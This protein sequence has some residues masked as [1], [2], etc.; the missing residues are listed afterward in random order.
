MSERYFRHRGDIG[1]GLDELHAQLACSVG[2]EVEEDRRVLSRPQPWTAGNG[3]RL[4]ELVR[5]LALIATAHRLDRIGSLLPSSLDDR[6]ERPLRPFP[7]PVAVHGVVAARDGSRS[8]RPAARRGRS[9]LSGARRP[10]TVREGVDPGLLGRR[11]GGERA[12]DRCANALRRGRRGRAD[13]TR[14][15]RSKAAVRAG[16]LKKEPSSIA[17]SRASDPETTLGRSRS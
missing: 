15:P 5:D 10:A 6:V 12:D 14:S 13:E 3:D 8:F 11:S 9:P 16:F 1:T 4:D 17:C 7:A 2:S